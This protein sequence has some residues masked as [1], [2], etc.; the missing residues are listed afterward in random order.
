[1]P[2][3]FKQYSECRGLVHWLLLLEQTR[4]GCHK[5]KN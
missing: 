4:F 2:G 5:F 3:H 1:M